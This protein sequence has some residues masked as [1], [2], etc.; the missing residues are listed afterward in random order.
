MISA[1][2]GPDGT[3]LTGSGGRALYLWV[4]D[5]HGKSVCSGACAKVWPPVLTS[6]AP[7]AGSGVLGSDLGTTTRSDGKK[8]V[9]YKGHPLYYYITDTAPGQLTGQGSNS[10]GAKWWLVAPSGS[11]ITSGGS[12]S[13]TSGAGYGYSAG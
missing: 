8:Q 12:T 11:A 3:Y 5:T 7:T 1:A 13:G 10:F 9:T 6:A 2:K 4:A